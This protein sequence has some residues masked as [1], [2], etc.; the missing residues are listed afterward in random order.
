M[1]I[2]KGVPQIPNGKYH[3]IV[4]EMENGDSVLCTKKEA[5]ALRGAIVKYCP[6]YKARM[7]I[8]R[9]ELKRSEHGYNQQMYR[10]WKVK[11]NNEVGH[12]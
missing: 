6:G 3:R 2:D 4:L 8:C 11:T 5:G 10:V 7:R 9:E 1:K 12:T